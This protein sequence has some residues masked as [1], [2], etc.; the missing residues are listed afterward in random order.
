MPSAPMS[1]AVGMKSMS[2]LLR[3]LLNATFCLKARQVLVNPRCFVHSLTPP[4]SNLFSLRET[5]I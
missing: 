5:Q 4:A 2:L 3:S 1:L